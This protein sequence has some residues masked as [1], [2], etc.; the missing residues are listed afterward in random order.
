MEQPVIEPPTDEGQNGGNDMNPPQ[1]ESFLHKVWRFILGLLGLDSGI[2]TPT[3]P[4]NIPQEPTSPEG[5]I[6]IPVQPP[7]KGP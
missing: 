4:E 2:N 7:L 1:T 6:I 5:P 3:N